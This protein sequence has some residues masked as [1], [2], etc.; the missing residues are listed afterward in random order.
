MAKLFFGNSR[1]A[2]QRKR[3]GIILSHVT[4]KRTP[5]LRI[6]EKEW[7]QYP[8][9][10]IRFTVKVGLFLGEEIKVNVI[11]GGDVGGTGSGVM[12]VKLFR[13]RREACW[14]WNEYTDAVTAAAVLLTYLGVSAAAEAALSM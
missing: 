6:D 14:G 9:L 10:C 1:T 2:Q 3:E 8:S 7:L 5:G 4:W 13:F 12:S 11:G